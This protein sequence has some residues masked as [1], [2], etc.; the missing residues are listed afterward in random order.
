MTNRRQ[1]ITAAI[2]LLSM[3]ITRAQTVVS[4]EGDQF[5][6]NGKPTYEGRYW[7]GNKIEGFLMI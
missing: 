7:K 4:I 1:I 3:G 2:L 5:F 6:I